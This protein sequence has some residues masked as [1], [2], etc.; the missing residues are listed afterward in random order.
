MTINKGRTTKGLIHADLKLLNELIIKANTQQLLFI[1]LEVGR[2]LK[3]R[4]DPSL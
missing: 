1:K 4:A 3:K 2:E